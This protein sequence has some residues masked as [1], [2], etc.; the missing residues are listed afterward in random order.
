MTRAPRNRIALELREEAVAAI[1][2][3]AAA[4]DTRPTLATSLVG[5][6]CDRRIAHHLHGTPPAN[7]PDPLAG[8][9]RAGA[10]RAL[11]AAVDAYDGADEEG[12]FLAPYADN[13]R[14]ATGKI[15]AVREWLSAPAGIYDLYED[16]VFAFKQ[17]GAHTM[18]RLR[19]RGPSVAYRTQAHIRARGWADAGY[20]PHHVAIIFVPWESSPQHHIRCS[21]DYIW[22]WSEAYDPA[23]P[24]ATL[25]RAERIRADL[26]EMDM[27]AMPELWEA[28]PTTPGE[29]RACPFYSPLAAPGAG[30]P[31]E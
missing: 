24:E 12:A 21:L 5:H 13:P 26:S 15:P 19:N 10:H 1:R 25:E 22:T 16:T 9:L 7:A 20:E 29:C 27:N 3:H 6:P 17:V 4:R 28:I 23:V 8:F 18:S 30:C 2:Q 31:G 11:G 14:Y